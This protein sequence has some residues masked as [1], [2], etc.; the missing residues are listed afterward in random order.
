LVG[1]C[2]QLL[3]AGGYAKRAANLQPGT[4]SVSATSTAALR[5]AASRGTHSC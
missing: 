3:I 1:A 4:V 5:S 2:P